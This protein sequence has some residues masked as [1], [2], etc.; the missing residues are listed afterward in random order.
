M[1]WVCLQG[2]GCHD[3]EALTAEDETRMHTGHGLLHHACLKHCQVEVSALM[4]FRYAVTWLH[5]CSCSYC[6]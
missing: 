1:K 4:G 5:Q 2:S 3:A 6:S